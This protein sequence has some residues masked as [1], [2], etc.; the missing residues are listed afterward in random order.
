MP[1]PQCSK[2]LLVSLALT[3]ESAIPR[4]ST[5]PSRAPT[6]SVGLLLLVNVLLY[7]RAELL[8]GEPLLG[9]N[10]IS[11]L[12][13]C[14]EEL[15]V[16][17]GIQVVT[18]QRTL[19]WGRGKPPPEQCPS[20]ARKPP[21]HHAQC[22]RHAPQSIASR[23]TPETLPPVVRRLPGPRVEEEPAGIPAVREVEQILEASGLGVE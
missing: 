20:S 19:A 14:F 3:A 21:K 6:Q 13:G 8:V 2:K 17:V 11:V 23:S 10:L 1:Y 4:A 7:E 15:F 9:M 22:R 12:A 5:R 16:V 18:L